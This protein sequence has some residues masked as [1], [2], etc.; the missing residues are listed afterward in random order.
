V[1]IQKQCERFLILQGILAV[2]TANR[3]LSNECHWLNIKTM[4]FPLIT[5]EW[6]LPRT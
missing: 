5:T 6:F 2:S 3:F 4:Y 1:L